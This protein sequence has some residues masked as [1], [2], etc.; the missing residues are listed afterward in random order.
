M[1]EETDKRNI[2]G[3]YQWDR[4]DRNQRVSDER[5]QRLEDKV[6]G[7]NKAEG[8]VEVGQATLQEQ[9]AALKALCHTIDRDI[10]DNHSQIE[11]QRDRIDNT[12]TATSHKFE[13]SLAATNK[14]SEDALL[15][16]NK[17]FD[18]ALAATNKKSEE[19]LAASNKK[20]EDALL[21]TNKKFDDALLATNK[22]S[23][24]ALSAT[25]M[26]FDENRTYFNRWFVA[27]IAGVTML[28]FVV[29]VTLLTHTFGGL[30]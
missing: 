21:T 9:I 30:A 26:K 12:L 23:E 29:I 19:A 18:E 7:V 2:N 13:E 11:L 10:M 5:I 4:G 17:K 6:N 14:K 1:G 22:K 27:T 28:L 8:R 25:N 16:T 24:D 20:F 3:S 15:T